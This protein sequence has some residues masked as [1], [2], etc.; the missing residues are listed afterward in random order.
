[1]ELVE[2]ASAGLAVLKLLI[3][4]MI[5]DF[6]SPFLLPPPAAHCLSDCRGG[7]GCWCAGGHVLCC[8][9]SSPPQKFGAVQFAS[10]AALPGK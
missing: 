9:A 10:L 7:G 3:M 5:N 2:A 8:L 6:C 4:T 1:M